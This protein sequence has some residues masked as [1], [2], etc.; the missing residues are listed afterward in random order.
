MGVDYTAEAKRM[1]AQMKDRRPT[2]AAP[3]EVSGSYRENYPVQRDEKAIQED[4]RPYGPLKECPG[5][6]TSSDYDGYKN[7]ASGPSNATICVEGD[8]TEKDVHLH[9]ACFTCKYR[10]AILPLHTKP[11]RWSSNFDRFPWFVLPLIGGVIT[12]L[13]TPKPFAFILGIHTGL[14]V[15]LLLYWLV[16]REE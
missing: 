5:C 2:R 4:T 9:Q 1:F 11:K 14:V 7:K 16:R 3:K 15:G 12:L 13:L 6:G 10:W 8:C